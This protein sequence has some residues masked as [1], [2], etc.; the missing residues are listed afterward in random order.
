MEHDEQIK[1]DIKRL[2]WNSSSNE[3][4][5]S[6]VLTELL[7]KEPMTNAEKKY[8]KDRISEMVSNFTE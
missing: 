5:I 6:K 3:E 1:R 7:K 4:L 8:W 2:Q